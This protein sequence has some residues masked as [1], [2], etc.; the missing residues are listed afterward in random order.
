MPPTR[1]GSRKKHKP[2]P[3]RKHK[4]KP[5]RKHKPKPR[6]KHKPKLLLKPRPNPTQLPNPSTI[7][8]KALRASKVLRMR[9]LRKSSHR[10]AD[11]KLLRTCLGCRSR[12]QQRNLVRIAAASCA[13]RR[14]FA[15]SMPGRP[16]Y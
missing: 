4:P 2:K 10:K 3:K 6:K 16:G 12:D 8:P 9:M 11:H 13:V 7:T 14:A 15:R 1:S 5:K